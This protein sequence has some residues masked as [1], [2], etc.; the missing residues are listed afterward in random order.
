[1][2][3]DKYDLLLNPHK[4]LNRWKDYFYLLLNV[5]EKNG[6]RQKEMHTAEPFVPE[7]SATEVKVANGKLKRYKSPGDDQ[8]SAELIQAGGEIL[9]S[10]ILKFIK[11]IWNKEELPIQQKE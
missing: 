1:L 6:V 3:E 8:I 5:H 10:E 9:R 11:L 7:S 2:A 4:I